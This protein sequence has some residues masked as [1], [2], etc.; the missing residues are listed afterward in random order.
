MYPFDKE[1]NNKSQRNPS[2]E[3]HL[4]HQKTVTSACVALGPLSQWK[5]SIGWPFLW[6]YGASFLTN[7]SWR[8]W[9]SEYASKDKMWRV[10][11]INAPTH[12]QLSTRFDKRK[13]RW[14]DNDLCSRSHLERQTLLMFVSHQSV[15]TLGILLAVDKFEW[16]LCGVLRLG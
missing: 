5:A 3:K 2:K 14:G 10:E 12:P 11:I 8:A 15:R 9:L 6:M 1:R 13:R 7:K 4:S 16:A